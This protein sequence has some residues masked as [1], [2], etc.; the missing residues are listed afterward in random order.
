MLQGGIVGPEFENFLSKDWG[1]TY[2]I[3]D[4]KRKWFQHGLYPLTHGRN[5]TV[6][7]L[8]VQ[9][10]TAARPLRFVGASAGA[11]AALYFGAHLQADVVVA[12]APQTL[13]DE[14]TYNRF[15]RGS[16]QDGVY[17]FADPENDI[18][19]V[20]EA[21]PMQGKAFVVFGQEHKVDRTQCERL[22]GLP[23]ILL[24]PYP[25]AQHTLLTRQLIKSG[26]L[27]GLLAGET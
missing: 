3:K 22:E 16:P 9:L 4:F 8:R 13:I 18:R 1:D 5:E 10:E 21:N 25:S 27:A 6:E 24:R 12:V 19:N 7:F 15:Q 20:L 17:D 2:F 11:Y 14:P 23:N 26:V